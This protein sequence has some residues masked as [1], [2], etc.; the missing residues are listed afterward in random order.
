MAVEKMFWV[1]HPPPPPP[2]QAA[3]RCFVPASSLS[4]FHVT[5]R[6]DERRWGGKDA[7]PFSRVAFSEVGFQRHVFFFSADP[8]VTRADSVVVAASRRPSLR[9]DV[10]IISHQAQRQ[11]TGLKTTE[12]TV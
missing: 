3:A 7:P 8:A 12:S 1:P 11:R 5:R 4:H 2:H 9:S 6:E 10:A